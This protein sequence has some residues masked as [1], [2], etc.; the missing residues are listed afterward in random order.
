[1]AFYNAIM[2]VIDRARTGST[3]SSSAKRTENFDAL[4]ATVA[5]YPPERVAPVC[6]I[7]AETIREVARLDRQRE[8]HDR[9][10]GAWASASTR[11]APTTPAA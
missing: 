7:A 8:E 4:K 10:S 3:R 6:G 11:T 9:S 2:H 5:N 1:M